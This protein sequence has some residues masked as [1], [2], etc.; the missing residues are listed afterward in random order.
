MQIC[1]KALLAGLLIVSRRMG[2]DP[3]RGPGPG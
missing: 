1:G 3:A 2:A